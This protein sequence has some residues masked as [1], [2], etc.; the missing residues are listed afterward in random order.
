MTT[1]AYEPMGNRCD[2]PE[3]NG[4]LADINPNVN[5]HNLTGFCVISAIF[6]AGL[7]TNLVAASKI[8]DIFGFYLPASVFIWAI[9]YPCSDIVAEVY[10]RKLAN[11]MVIGGLVAFILSIIVIQTAVIMRPAPFWGKQEAFESV[12]QSSLRISLALIVSYSVTQFF[13]VYIFGFIRKRTG[14]KRLWLRNNIST[15]CSQ[16]LANTI[17]LSL[18]FLG[19][20]PMEKWFDLFTNNLMVRYML[21]FS[22]TAIVY[23]GVYTLYRFYPALNPLHKKHE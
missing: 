16:T 21:A 8:V 1:I 15:L 18:A 22:D 9:T 2:H 20:I 19:T 10:G 6:I 17:F 5:T 11:K 14:N 23:I 13:D 3:Q 12:L 4:H 7:L